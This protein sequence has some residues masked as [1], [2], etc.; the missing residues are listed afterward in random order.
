MKKIS[1]IFYLSLLLFTSGGYR[2]LVNWLEHR[3]QQ[4]MQVVIEERNF[5]PAQ[6][7]E[8]SVSL[9]LPYLSDWHDWEAVEG[10]VSIDGTPHQYVE[11][12]LKGGK[13][14]Y[15]C[16][17]NNGME[18][19]QSARDRFMQ[20]SYH[21]THPGTQK[22]PVNTTVSIKPPLPDLICL[23]R[24]SI[25]PLTIAKPLKPEISFV[26]RALP[27]ATVSVPTPPPDFA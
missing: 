9:D 24:F 27:S 18:Q 11:R 4:D 12:M 1:T 19:V 20:F 8:L 2:V 23:D 25:N 16:L 22:N 10:I 3:A 7:V 5:D 13:M 21:F 6:L 14:H 26:N 15:R 17:P